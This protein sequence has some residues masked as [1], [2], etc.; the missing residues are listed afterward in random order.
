[1]SSAPIRIEVNIPA[2]SFVKGPVKRPE[3][4]I[5]SGLRDSCVW[6]DENLNICTSYHNNPIVIPLQWQKTTACV[7][8]RPDK[9]C[10]GYDVV[11]IIDPGDAYCYPVIITKVACEE[12]AN[13]A[14]KAI[15]NAIAKHVGEAN[16]DGGTESNDDDLPNLEE[17]EDTEE[18][19]AKA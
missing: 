11:Y 12:E 10:G 15:R 8:G 4:A 17:V 2:N 1:M 7:K 18:S 6:V 19:G 5:F 13:E 14:A 16:R 9:F 3:D